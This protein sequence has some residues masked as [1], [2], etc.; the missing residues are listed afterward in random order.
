MERAERFSRYTVTDATGGS[1]SVTND[2]AAWMRVPEGATI[3]NSDGF[4][5]KNIPPGPYQVVTTAPDRLVTSKGMS[6]Y[7]QI[8]QK[9][10]PLSTARI[11]AQEKR[12][13]RERVKVEEQYEAWDMAFDTSIPVVGFAF[14]II[15]NKEPRVAA[16]VQAVEGEWSVTEGPSRVSWE[17]LLAWL[18]EN[19]VSPEDIVRP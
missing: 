3:T 2:H 9:E 15:Q 8:Q 16:C 1:Y 10:E 17:D 13:A 18:I 19:N 6:Y 7:G 5:W 11:I 14:G 4:V 12:L